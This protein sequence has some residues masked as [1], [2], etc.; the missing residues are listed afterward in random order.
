M[1]R[2]FIKICLYTRPFYHNSD[3]GCGYD[4]NNTTNV[5]LLDIVMVSPY[6]SDTFCLCRTRGTLWYQHRLTKRT[7]RVCVFRCT[8]SRPRQQSG[9]EPRYVQLCHIY[10]QWCPF[11]A[12]WHISVVD[13][14]SHAAPYSIRQYGKNTFQEK[15]ALVIFHISGLIY[16]EVN[17]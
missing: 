5:A 15:T 7:Q 1:C 17:I 3:T 2:L 4:I 6:D 8:T 12:G 9:R 10:G 13:A 16:V 11:H 14:A